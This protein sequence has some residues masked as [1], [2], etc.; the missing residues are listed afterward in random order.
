MSFCYTIIMLNITLSPMPSDDVSL[1]VI[2][3]EIATLSALIGAATHRL[4][5]LIG[6][7]DRK[8]GWA[9]PL[10]PRGFR[11]CAHWLSWR[12]GLSPGTARNYVRI[13]RALP[14]LALISDAFATGEVSYSKVRAI[15]PIATP[16]NEEMLLDWARAGTA[17]QV[18]RLVREFRRAD[19]DRENDRAV[20]QEESRYLTT[21]FDNDGMLVVRGRLSPEQGALLL[22][23]SEVSGDELWADARVPAGTPGD[24]AVTGNQLRADALARVAERA[25]ACDAAQASSSDRYQVVVHVDAEVLAEPAV[26]G[27]CHLEDGPAL[28]PETVRRLAC[29]STLSVMHHGP[30]GALTAGRKT[31]AISAPLRRALKARDGTRCAF[32]GCQCRGRDAHHVQAWA[33]GGPTVLHNLATLCRAHHTLMHEGGYR[34]E[35]L[36]GGRFRFLRPDGREVLAA[37]TV[38]PVDPDPVSVLATDWLPPDLSVTPDTGRATW[39]GEPVDYEWSVAL[40]CQ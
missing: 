20:V 25:L 26:D 29:D 14:D 7:V 9:D 32:P 27:R 39:D 19:P 4:I 10:D 18:E 2:E 6:E 23:A 37:P 22:K 15:I 5:C 40:L 1:E 12:V 34:I 24:V 21:W 13:A 35:P 30:D 31:R 36:A 38:G 8:D 17:S 16:D 33:K 11:S 28:A 3:D